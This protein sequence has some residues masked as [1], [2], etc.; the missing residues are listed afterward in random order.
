MADAHR[1]A[2]RESE[3]EEGS[4]FRARVRRRSALCK[5][6]LS[7]PPRTRRSCSCTNAFATMSYGDPGGLSVPLVRWHEITVMLTVQESNRDPNQKQRGV[8]GRLRSQRKTVTATL[9]GGFE[10]GK[11]KT[12]GRREPLPMGRWIVRPDGH[13]GSALL[14]ATTWCLPDNE[15]VSVRIDKIDLSCPRGLHCIVFLPGWGEHISHSRHEKEV[16]KSE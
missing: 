11:S 10:D 12:P 15:Y 14:F 1:R 13:T 7:Q 4:C 2:R 6:Q 16:A 9:K 5:F 3:N 8:G